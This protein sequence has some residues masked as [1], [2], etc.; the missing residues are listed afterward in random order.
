MCIRD[1]NLTLSLVTN[2]NKYDL[3]KNPDIRITLPDEIE[4]INAG[5]I[6]LVYNEELKFEYARLEENGRV[7][8]LKLT[9]E[10]TNYKLGIQEGTKILIQAVISIKEDVYKRQA[11]RFSRIE[12]STSICRGKS[13]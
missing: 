12:R 10:E 7:L 9:G 6:S 4:S 11:N 8:V 3:F 1:R 5:E 2:S 13:C